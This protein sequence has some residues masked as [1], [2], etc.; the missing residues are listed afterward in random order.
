MR[1][2]YLF[3]III[4]FFLLIYTQTSHENYENF[5]SN[6]TIIWSYWE[7]KEGTIK[8]PY[9]DLCY[10][11]LEHHCSEK[12][13]IIILNEK[14]VYDY[15]PNLRKDINKLQLALK[16]DYIRVLLLCVYG[17]IWIDADTII[18]N[19]LD[20]LDDKL[21]KW[22]FVGF[23]CS[24]S[25]CFNGYPYPSNGVMASK[26]NGI[27]IKKC[28]MALD[29]LLG[30]KTHDFGYFDLGKHIIWGELDKLIKNDN[31]RYYH[32]SSEYDGSRDI[33][34]HWVNVDNHI[35]TSKTKLLNEDK[36]FFVFLENNKF[37]GSDQKYNW[38]SKLSEEDIL[39]GPYW[40]SYLFNKSL[41]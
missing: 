16:V 20:D 35:S 8:P 22:D 21:K 3:V 18:M 19:N 40:I 28:L 5:D 27:L 7:N 37:I 29:R 6:K 39:N 33:D 14:T 11:T 38:F 41:S 1:C 32:Y 24:K 15:L 13:D 26:K 30:K 2:I 31:Y 4:I 23:G 25:T 12:F 10:K 36:L 9:I 17:G 34:G